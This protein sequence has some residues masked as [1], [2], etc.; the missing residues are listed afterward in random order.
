MS[1]G[2]LTLVFRPDP[3]VWDGFAADNAWLQELPKPISKIVWENVVGIGPGLAA[4]QHLANGDVVRVEAGGRT[5]EGPVWVFG[6]QSD[7]VV[8]VT[9]GYGRQVA[10]QLSAGLGYNAYTLR[11]SDTPWV[12][13]EVTLHATGEHRTLATTQDHTA[14]EGHDFVRVQHAGAPPVGDGAYR[15]PTLYPDHH[16]DGRAWGMVID[17]DTCIGCNACVTACQSG[18][19][20]RRR[21]PRR[22]VERPRDALAAR[23]CLSIARAGHGAGRC[24]PTGAG[25]FHAR[26]LH[27]L[28]TGAVRGRLPCGSH[29]ARP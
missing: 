9:L 11:R 14:M 3:T 18:E 25:A 17:L 26:A 1:T 24:H 12:A 10:G 22:G 23:G 5:A 7:D 21:R 13:G 16:S 19:Q 28:R 20:H 27:A 8:S 15:P 6:G 4:R 29:V 2:A